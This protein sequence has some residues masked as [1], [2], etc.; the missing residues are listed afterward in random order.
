LV[1]VCV[2]NLHCITVFSAVNSY[3]NDFK[4][5]I[6]SFALNPSIND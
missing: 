1:C 4:R 5:L 6:L 2:F 3:K